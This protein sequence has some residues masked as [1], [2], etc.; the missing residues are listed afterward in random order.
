MTPTLATNKDVI[1]N[2]TTTIEKYEQKNL[3]ELLEGSNMTPAKFKQI[4]ISELKKSD[5]LQQAFLNNPA[6]LFAS[7]LHCAELGLNPSQ[8]IGEFY[9]IPFKDTITPIL[10]YKGLLTLLMR[11]DKVKKIWSEVVYEGDDFIYELG[12]HP[13]LVH[14]PNH[15][16]IGKSANIKFVYACAKIDDEIVFKVM[17]KN[18]IQ[19]IINIAKFSN[20]LYFNDKK[21]PEQWMAKKTVLKQLAKL[22]PREDDRLKKAVSMDDQ[23]EGGGYLIM[24]ENDNV[25]FVQGTVIG[26]KSSIYDKLMQKNHTDNLIMENN[27]L[28]LNSLQS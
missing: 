26:K 18:E 11:S 12:M 3:L 22:M 25:K 20:D 9:F 16:A 1:G 14:A 28:S 2:F 17:S 19:N 23:M 13:T 10:G 24:D 6:S 4:V 15:E 8:T 5:K 27:T 21:D 7:I